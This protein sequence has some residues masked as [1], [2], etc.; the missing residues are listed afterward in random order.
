MNTLT[1]NNNLGMFMAKPVRVVIVLLGALLYSG[2]TRST[3]LSADASTTP[4][5]MVSKRPVTP[6][7]IAL[8]QDKSLSTGE[9][10]T[11]Q[12]QMSDLDPLVELLGQTGGELAVGIIHDRSNLGFVRLHIDSPPDEPVVP[13]KADNPLERRKQSGTLR[14]QTAEFKNRQQTWLDDMQT[15]VSNF[16]EALEP[17]LAMPAKA[18]HSP[19]WD[20]VRRSELFLSEGAA[21]GNAT[22]HRYSLYITDGLDDVGARPVP[23][24]SGAKLLMVNGAGQLGALVVLQPQRFESIEAAIR[25]I[26]AAETK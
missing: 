23:V 7:R 9:T 13:A 10:R 2:C 5:E 11:P 22:P 18:Q 15:R 26:V 19:V 20:A 14:K 17:V 1:E 6:L 25:F 12:L 16:Q 24:R 21:G 8:I 4:S 3:A